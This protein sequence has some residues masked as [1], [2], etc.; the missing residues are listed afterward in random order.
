LGA[1][2]DRIVVTGTSSGGHL[3]LALGFRLKRYGYKPRGIVANDPIC[4]DRAIYPSQKFEH[5]SWGAHQEHR[6]N[7]AWL[8]EDNYNLPT[9]SP[10][11]FPNRATVEECIGYPPTFIH[12]GENDPER[13]AGLSFAQKLLAANVF[14][15]IHEWAGSA[16]AAFIV[17]DPKLPIKQR[18]DAVFQ[19]NIADCL[20]Y[21]FRRSWLEDH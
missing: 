13:D 19:G 14:T 5:K 12:L 8:G 21:D 3:S 17:A 4:D 16:H 15:E 7:L 9:L 11:A 20:K 2:S 6:S 18:Y 1:D 10:E